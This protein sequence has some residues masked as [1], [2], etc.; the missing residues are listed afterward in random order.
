LVILAVIVVPLAQAGEIHDAITAGDRARVEALLRQNP[1]LAR[2]PNENP[3]RDLPMHTAAYAGQ[4]EIA[5]RLLDAGGEIEGVDSDGST[6]LHCAAVSR[7]PEMV[8]FLL[9]RGADVNRRDKNG[10]YSLSFAASAGDSAC[11]R[12]ILDAGADLNLITPQGTTLLHYAC[13][14]GL[15]WLADPILAAGGDINRGDREGVTPLHLLSQGRFPERVEQ[16]IVR[17]ADAAVAD[18]DGTTPLHFAS[19]FDRPEVARVLLAH[20]ADA[21]AADHRGSTPIIWASRGGA[22]MVRLLLEHGAEP[23]VRNEWG[24]TPL[25]A[26]VDNG[27]AETVDLLLRAGADPKPTEADF[28]MTSLHL[29]ALLGYRD[30][31]EALLSR[32]VDVNARDR[33]GRTPLDV[34]VQYGQRG[35]VEALA[36]AGA[37]PASNRS[38][39]SSAPFVMPRPGSEEAFV[40]SLGHSGWAVKTKNHVL[41]FD[42]GAMGRNPDQPSLRNG[43]INPVELAGEDVAVFASHEHGDHY[44]PAIFEWKAQIPRIRYLLGFRPRPTPAPVPGQAQAQ[45]Q[46]RILPTDYVYL[47]PGQS[48]TIDGMNVTT[49][50]SNDSGVGFL[51][52][53]DGVTIFHAGDHANRFRDM[54]GPFKPQI[55]GLVAKGVRPDLAFL[56]VSGCNFG[57][58][59]AV[60]I[61][62]EYQLARLQPKVFFPMHGGKRGVRLRDFVTELGPAFPATVKLAALSKGDSFHYRDGKVL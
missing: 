13:P 6:A 28:G 19:M 18:S 36:A 11:V 33:E 34:A 37:Q 56:P 47:A 16:A 35:V 21:N 55:D 57:D 45:A 3:T 60:K 30:V 39:A 38:G 51:V 44:D 59:V 61:G 8:H 26:A 4:V 27:N 62:V 53:V 7:K 29:A 43:S 50:E 15:W 25:L 41:V 22:P 14:R 42:A 2:A 24:Q 52:D 49:I 10:A 46:P 9:S 32:G 48:K 54:S 5:Q 12:M 17:G 1:S 31:A 23:N 58:Q 40:W 20:G